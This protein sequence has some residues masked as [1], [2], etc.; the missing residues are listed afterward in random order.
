MSRPMNPTTKRAITIIS[1]MD[2]AFTIEDL[3][4]K[5][6]MNRKDICNAMLTIKRKGIVRTIGYRRAKTRPMEV[7]VPEHVAEARVERNKSLVVIEG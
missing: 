2:S 6:F 3:A 1:K 7:Y 4:K 5:A